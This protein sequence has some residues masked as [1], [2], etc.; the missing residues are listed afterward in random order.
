MQQM[1]VEY[2]LSPPRVFFSS[3]AAGGSVGRAAVPETEMPDV[4][5]GKAVHRGC[6]GGV[7]VAGRIMISGGV[8]RVVT[9]NAISGCIVNS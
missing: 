6:G 4:G 8:D 7:G 2:S 5:W 3:R 9:V 1:R